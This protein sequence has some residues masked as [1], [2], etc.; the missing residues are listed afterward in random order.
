MKIYFSI[1]LLMFCISCSS[2]NRQSEINNVN[3][4]YGVSVKSDVVNAIGLPNKIESKDGNEY[5][6]YSG[7]ET[8]SDFFIPLPISASPAGG[9]MYN[10]YYTDIGPQFEVEFE[11]IYVCVFDESSFLIDSFDPRKK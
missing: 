3:F 11:A 7:K 9:G 8:G 1:V 2:I 10:V 6:I 5:W 4:E